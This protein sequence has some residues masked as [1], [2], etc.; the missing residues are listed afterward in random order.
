MSPSFHSG[1]AIR[2]LK[3]KFLSGS[4]AVCMRF[5]TLDVAKEFSAHA[6]NDKRPDARTKSDDLLSFEEN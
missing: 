1:T 4:I 5:C 6:T 2:A 3:F